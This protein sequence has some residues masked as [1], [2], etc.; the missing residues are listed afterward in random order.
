[1]RELEHLKA[2]R[3]L[4][5]HG[6]ENVNAREATLAKL[7]EKKNLIMLSL[8]WL[9]G[10]L[11]ADAEERVLNNLEPHMNLVELNIEGYN[12]M[13]SPCWM[14][15]PMLTNLTYISLS[16]CNNWQ[17][18]PPLGRLRSLKYLYLQDM[19]AVKRIE[20][21]FYGHEGVFAFPS[22]KLLLLKRLPSL[23]EWVEAEG[24]IMFPRLVEL[25]IGQCRALRKIPALPPSLAYLEIHDVGLSTLPATYHSSEPTVPQKPLRSRLQIVWCSNL[26]TL[27]QEYCFLCL[28]ELDIQY[29]ENLLHLPMDRLQAP[30][31]LKKLTVVGCPKLMA[32]QADISLPSS[33]R[34][35]YVDPCGAYETCLL[36]S[37]RS[38]T[39]LTTLCLANCVMTALPSADIFRSL[40]AV[41]HLT[42]VRC[43]EL[44]SLGGIEELA[45]LTELAV[46]ACDKLLGIRPQEMFQAS[47]PNQITVVYHSH[48]G[49]LQKLTISDP[50]VLQLEPLRIVN[51]VGCLNI[52]SSF[53][54]LPDEWLMQN[55]NHLKRLGVH[56]ASRLEFLPSIM[57]RLTSLETLEFKRAILIQSLP[58]L[59][60]SLRVLHFLGCHPVLKQRCRKRRGHDWHKIAHIPVVRIEQDSPSSWTW[61]SY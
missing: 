59:P 1:M 2:L 55:C 19:K 57:A 46:C 39:S 35:F 22:L 53:R 7:G 29:C 61:H 20:D 37:L 24:M 40:A 25:C 52:T 16:C 12:G 27:G 31:L 38:L 15:I 32:P 14:E 10:Q 45:S 41:Q 43:N 3:H 18:L 26:V 30:S 13:R 33:I 36:T 6:L 34:E 5:V 9:S 60:A 23:E 47:D 50:Y 48:L 56:D 44:A 21:S 49:R 58:E 28:E 42:I 11:E 4:Y 17:H 8:T 51:S 54:C